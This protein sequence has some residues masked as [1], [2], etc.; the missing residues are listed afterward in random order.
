MELEKSFYKHLAQTT[1]SPMLLKFSK[2]NGIYL[3]DDKDEKYSNALREVINEENKS[4]ALMK[5][6]SD[7]KCFHE[8]ALEKSI[9]NTQKLRQNNSLNIDYLNDERERSLIEFNKIENG[10][11]KDIEAYVEKYNKQ[12]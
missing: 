12:I 9:Q 10:Q 11:E 1:G 3:Y 7:N 2:A 6:I 8:I 4:S 5:E